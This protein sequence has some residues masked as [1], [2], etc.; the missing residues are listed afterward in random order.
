MSGVEVKVIVTRSGRVSKPPKHYEPEEVCDDDY[1]DNDYDSD[2]DVESILTS[3][4]ESVDET[5]EEE[6]VNGNLKGF[7]VDESDSEND[8]SECD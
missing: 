5:E 2:S 4:D 6:D 7:V 8:E 1:S 3:D